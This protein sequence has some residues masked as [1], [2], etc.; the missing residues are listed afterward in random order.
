[1]DHNTDKQIEKMVDK[2]MKE[3]SL[4]SPSFNFTDMVMAQVLEA[5]TSQV[6][7]YK[8]L[9]SK[10][11]WYAVFASMIGLMVYLTFNDSNPAST[12]L[13]DKLNLKALPSL[14]ISKAFENFHYSRTTIYACVLL[15]VM[16]FV[17]IPILKYYMDKKLEV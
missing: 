6:T 15:T 9:I 10:W 17:Q 2:M 4:E 16:L 1:M 11:I 5:K 13:F 8:P 7:V 3:T 14:N 12:G